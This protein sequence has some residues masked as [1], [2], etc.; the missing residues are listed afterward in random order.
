MP[1][2]TTVLPQNRLLRSL[3]PQDLA[4]LRPQ[5]ERFP[6]TPKRVLHHAR[7][8]IEHVYFVESGLVSV[9]ARTDGANHGVE[10]WLIGHEGMVGL[11]VVLGMETS[12]HRRMVQVEGSALRMTAA[13][14]RNAMDDLP[15]LRA[16]LLRYVNSILIQASQSSVC[17]A[18]HSL[19]Q[20]L[21][22]WLLMVED[23]L[24]RADLPVTHSTIA[25]ILGGRRAS[26]TEGIHL[27]AAAE[28][29]AQERGLIRIRDS[30]RLEHLSCDCYRIM[31]IE[32]ERLPRPAGAACPSPDMKPAPGATYPIDDLLELSR[33]LD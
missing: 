13:D 26:I 22:R 31:K 15:S 3:A 12:P 19:L 27:L 9:L 11:P 33:D 16:V 30:N 8:P 32:F 21:A 17:H 14:L 5:L 1:H 24:G 25:K 6:L 4:R 7:L 29:I 18:S 20:R 10:A 23:R 2:A 28:A